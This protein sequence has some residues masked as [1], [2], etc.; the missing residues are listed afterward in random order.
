MRRTLVVL[1]EQHTLLPEQ[2]KLLTEK[3][4]GV[5]DMMWELLTVPEQ[6]WTSTEQKALVEKF[7]K[8]EEISTFVFASPV[9]LLLKLVARN[10]VDSTRE[11][12]FPQFEPRWDVWVFHNDQRIK[13]EVRQSDGTVKIVFTV[14]STGW[15]LL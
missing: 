13:K 2:A 8:V 1:N 6:G 11:I 4:G 14:A 15:Q 3:F 5:A 9:P 12:N 7:E 10:M